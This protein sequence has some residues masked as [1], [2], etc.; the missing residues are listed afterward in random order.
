MKYLGGKHKIGKE[1]SDFLCSQC[2]P[3]KVDGY[4]EPFCGSL[5]VFKHMTNRGY[6]NCIASDIQPDLIDLWTSLQNNNLQLPEKFSI[7]LYNDLKNNTQQSPNYLKAVAGFGLSFGGN[8]FSGYCQKYDPKRDYYNAFKN[9]LNKI[10]PQLN[11][12]QFHH[13]SYLDYKP[14]NMLIYC[15]PPYYKTAIYKSTEPFNHEL[16]W[17]TMREWSLT[18]YVFISEETAPLDFVQVFSIQKRRTISKINR[19]FKTESLYCMGNGFSRG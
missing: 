13:K 9:S 7:D 10:K 1:I 3:C 17:D 6:K 8:Y 4:L 18:N 2:S 15:D 14:V 5:G 16:F 11:N 12:V 19:P